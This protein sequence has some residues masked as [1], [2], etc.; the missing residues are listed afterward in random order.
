MLLVKIP[1]TSRELQRGMRP[2]R[3]KAPYVGFNPII[4][5]NEAGTRTD[6]PVSDPI[7][8]LTIHYHYPP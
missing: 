5:Q 4:P 8:L 6:P 1:G 7:E 2:Y 3:E